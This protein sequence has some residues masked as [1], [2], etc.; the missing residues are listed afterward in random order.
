M[1]KEILEQDAQQAEWTPSD[2][3]TQKINEIAEELSEHGM[4][5]TMNFGFGTVN[6][7]FTE[8]ASEYNDDEDSDDEDDS[9]DEDEDED[10]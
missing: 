1:K 8:K 4:K 3:L 7:E 10:E 6:F 5:F 2:E 9:G